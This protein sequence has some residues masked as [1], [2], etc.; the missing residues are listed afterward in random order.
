MVGNL[1]GNV[2][3]GGTVASIVPVPEGANAGD[4]VTIHELFRRTDAVT[5]DAVLDAAV[6]GLLVI[7]I[8]HTFTLDEIGAARNAVAAGAPGQGRAQALREQDKA[9]AG[10]RSL[11]HAPRSGGCTGRLLTTKHPS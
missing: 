4:R 7:P 11:D 8:S 6:R 9:G 1:I 5:L 10:C 3:D 2:R